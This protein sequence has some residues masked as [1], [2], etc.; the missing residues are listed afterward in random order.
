MG[1][2]SME[3]RG[4]LLNGNLR[5]QSRLM[6]GIKILVEIPYGEKKNGSKEKHIDH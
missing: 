2:G 6:E 1:L 4:S 3:E 5:I